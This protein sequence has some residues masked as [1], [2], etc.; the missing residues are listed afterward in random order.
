[1]KGFPG[2]PGAKGEKGHPGRDGLEGLP[3]SKLSEFMSIF[4]VA[5]K[6]TNT[7][8][9]FCMYNTTSAFLGSW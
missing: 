4:E 1:M 2:Q 8:V 3:V 6:Q 5:A 9:Y 7:G